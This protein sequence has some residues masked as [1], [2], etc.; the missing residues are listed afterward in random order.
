MKLIVC[1]DD[2][3]GMLF[4]KRRQSSDKRVIDSILSLVRENKLRVNPY[5]AALF[6]DDERLVIDEE[7]LSN[8]QIGEYCFVE[9]VD[10][11]CY[12]PLAEQIIL[13][14]WNR[15]YPSDLCFPL[16]ALEDGWKLL[17]SEDFAGNSHE[18]ITMEVYMR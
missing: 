6:P 8:A 14:R 13:Y 5:T 9:N 1:I 16:A 11:M 12:I 18:R 7:S 4:N 3:G 17:S 15:K 2:A 10:V